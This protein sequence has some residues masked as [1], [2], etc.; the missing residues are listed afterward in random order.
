MLESGLQGVDEQEGDGAQQ[1]DDEAEHFAALAAYEVHLDLPHMQCTFQ[2]AD[3]RLE[4]MGLAFA[5]S[6]ASGGGVG[7]VV[8]ACTPRFSRSL[9][10]LSHLAMEG[11]GG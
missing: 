9:E 6:A 4:G 11:G 3:I 1:D 8:S 10:P 7:V 2:M 5:Q